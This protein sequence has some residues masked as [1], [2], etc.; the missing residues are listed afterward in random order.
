MLLDRCGLLTGKTHK[1]IEISLE[2]E[3]TD[4]IEIM[5]TQEEHCLLTHRAVRIICILLRPIGATAK[6]RF[7]TLIRCPTSRSQNKRR[8]RK[9]TNIADI[10]LFI[11]LELS[12][13][14]SIERT[15]TSFA[16]PIDIHKHIF[17]LKA[18][19]E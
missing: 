1:G 8:G 4:L 13:T 12:R 11:N 5:L 15:P 2:T 19:L 17:T 10:P 6:V 3:E 16:E 7:R 14:F 9:T 18:V